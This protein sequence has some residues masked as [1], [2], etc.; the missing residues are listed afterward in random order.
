MTDTVE[1]PRNPLDFQIDLLSAPALQLLREWQGL[2]KSF[3]RE[4]LP[5]A[6]SELAQMG[7]VKV[8]PTSD[9]RGI[10]TMRAVLTFDGHNANLRVA[11]GMYAHH[12]EIY[13][14]RAER[15]AASIAVQHGLECIPG[16]GMFA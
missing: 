3:E 9:H 12:K 8:E 16:W 1:L 5:D 7:F 6:V 15:D 14:Q 11:S 4:Y 10:I 2:D 13:R